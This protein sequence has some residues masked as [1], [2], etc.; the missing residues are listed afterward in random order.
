MNL[1]R[2]D[3]LDIEAR[4]V[5]GVGFPAMTHMD[6]TWPIEQF[7]ADVQAEELVGKPLKLAG[8]VVGH[9]TH[10]ERQVEAHRFLMRVQITDSKIA[11]QIAPTEEAISVGR[12]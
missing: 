12:E 5:A 6:L 11:A 8:K 7:N 2:P 3:D 10:A 1:L 4:P 9:V